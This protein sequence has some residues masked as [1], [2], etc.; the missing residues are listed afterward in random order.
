[1][2]N[3]TQI[4]LEKLSGGEL[5]QL[6]VKLLPIIHPRYENLIHSG[7]VE[8]TTKTR[9][10]TPDVWTKT[11][12][13][14]F[15][16]VQATSDSSKG[17][18][19][20]DV[21]KTILKFENENLEIKEYVAFL[22]F[23]P[24][25]SEVQQCENFCR[26]NNI[27]FTYFPNSKISLYLDLPHNHKLRLEFLGIQPSYNIFMTLIEFKERISR[28]SKNL[29][30][31]TEFIGR[32]S[33]IQNIL[34]KL[35]NGKRII[36]IDG[37]PGVGKT[38][39]SI[40]LVQRIVSI[41]YLKE[42]EIRF[43]TE[44]NGSLI[45]SIRSEI[46]A[47]KK[48]V[49]VADDANRLEY[50]S[51]LFQLILYPQIRDGSILILTTR[52][53]N[54]EQVVSEII[55]KNI[56]DFDKVS[57]KRLS[58]KDI[59][60]IVQKEP[61]NIHNESNR[62]DIVM[63]AKGNPRMAAILA[64]VIK[65]GN[66]IQGT[67]TS[68][69]FE[70]YFLSVFNDIEQLLNDAKEK[71]LLGLIASLRF[72]DLTN[73]KIVNQ[74]ST[75]SKISDEREFNECINTLVESEI[76]E[77]VPSRTVARIF[78]DSVSEYIVF[79]FF[80]DDRFPF[81][82][83]IENVV[84]PFAQNYSKHIFETLIALTHKGY[85]SNRLDETLAKL[86]HR[87]ETIL[88]NEE[89]ENVRIEYLKWMEV[90]A[91]SSPLECF[92]IVTSYAE[93]KGVGN[94]VQDEV[95]SIV[96]IIKRTY[97]VKWET[98]SYQ[99]FT[100][101]WKF[102]LIENKDFDS[103]AKNARSTLTKL[104]DYI[105]PDRDDKYT[106][107][108]YKPTKLL[109]DQLQNVI[110]NNHLQNEKEYELSIELL[111]RLTIHHFN[112]GEMS[113]IDKRTYHMSAGA[114]Y[115][116]NELKEIRNRTYSLLEKL[117]FE[118]QNKPKLRKSILRA[119]EEP[120]R[121]ILPFN[122]E[123]SNELM[124]FDAEIIL[125]H[126]EKFASIEKHFFLLDKICYL[127]YL[128]EKYI[129][130]ASIIRETIENPNLITFQRFHNSFQ[131]WKEIRKD[132]E[133]VQKEQN[134]FVENYLTT[135]TEENIYSII[136]ELSDIENQA[137]LENGNLT[138][139]RLLFS[140]L[141]K[142]KTSLAKIVLEQI[143]F[144]NHPL[145]VYANSLLIGISFS[146]INVK[147][148]IAKKW[149]IEN[150]IDK[151]R[152]LSSTYYLGSHSI[153]SLADIELLD[154]LFSLNDERIDNDLI[155]ALQKYQSL[156][157]EWVALKLLELSENISERTFSDLLMWMEPTDK[158]EEHHYQ[159]Y[160]SHPLIFKKIL[161]NTVRFPSIDGNSLGYHLS[162]CLETLY[163][164]EP[165]AILDFFLARLEIYK[166]LEKENYY[167]YKVLP[168][169]SLDFS[170]IV[171]TPHHKDLLQKILSFTI[172]DKKYYH[173]Y[174]ELVE[175]ILGKS[176]FRYGDDQG[177]D[178]DNITMEIL[179][180]WVRG[181]D[182][183]LKII[184]SFLHNNHPWTSWFELV[185]LILK[186]NPNQAIIRDLVSSLY[187]GGHSGPT[188]FFYKGRLEMIQNQLKQETSQEMIY[189]IAEAERFLKDMIQRAIEREEVD[190]L[191]F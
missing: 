87:T 68:E 158:Y 50:L 125:T 45:E 72:I 35:R 51:D 116:N 122:S 59:D 164:Q 89:N 80:F 15:I 44:I 4:L 102:S 162:K 156:N 104:F 145:F 139:M 147:N 1:M 114:L 29:L 141:G 66:T 23:E 160:K 115:L 20:D 181:T 163:I 143:S 169:S 123:P 138:P 40:E 43:V 180:N 142:Q 101:L 96:E 191:N 27:V 78:D 13:N 136:S 190:E 69:L 103:V 74:L 33:D 26:Q 82:N 151:L 172:Q 36:V 81:L 185:K 55:G 131:H 127:L 175:N 30:S 157:A 92:G 22:N 109:L 38:R 67:K 152:I 37:D 8:G 149:L 121:T 76:L 174:I 173:F 146:D 65:S 90:Y 52:S 111:S 159:T 2:L 108:F 64:G 31:T 94:L 91:Q 7:A 21:E 144:T 132:Y 110:E 165:E 188:S 183:Q 18:M 99:T 71:T 46:D 177:N 182:E 19:Y 58:N 10:G 61:F 84:V 9:K 54:V 179:K 85:Q 41:E 168:Y 119:F 97:F 5:Q 176:K 93:L 56:E 17:K 83:F 126:L 129:P 137:S 166:N 130:D 14:E 187:S 135:I 63:N 155:S 184:L 113:Y 16:C 62:R 39:L 11:T 25:T 153:V 133:T 112:K 28:K 49:V 79:R 161:F 117:Y 70:N 98:L 42:H 128:I 95:K 107:W 6:A 75:I 32:E 189:F 88:L 118:L 47:Q 73:S 34:E 12:N 77:V 134:E 150:D 120:L 171:G 170:F 60:D 186:R 53:Y 140:E 167:G 154:K 24:Q 106:Y 57:I 48:Y 100:S 105:P 148:E 124:K 178:F 3:H 86:V